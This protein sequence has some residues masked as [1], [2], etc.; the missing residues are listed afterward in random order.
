MLTLGAKWLI[1][2]L[3][4][5]AV[6]WFLPGFDVL[7]YMTALWAALLLGVLNVTLRP[8]LKLLSLPITVLTLGLFAFVVNGFVFWVGVRLVP[9]VAIT[10]FWWAVVAAFLVAVVTAIGNRL[11]LGSDGTL[12]SKD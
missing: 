4:I 9:G 2:A 8:I 10:S 5:F 6:A 1:S 11:F 7:D 3:A 12:G